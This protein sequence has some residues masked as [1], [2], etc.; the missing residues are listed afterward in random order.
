MFVLFL[1]I[2][3]CQF[4]ASYHTIMKGFVPG[5]L[6]VRYFFE[7]C[8]CFECIFKFTDVLL[9]IWYFLVF[10]DWPKTTA[11]ISSSHYSNVQLFD[12]SNKNNLLAPNVINIIAHKND[13]IFIFFAQNYLQCDTDDIS[14]C[15]SY[16]LLLLLR[17]VFKNDD[18]WKYA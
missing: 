3:A 13:F 11:E 14:I 16:F 2:D 18:I 4:P 1:W 15:I 12:S 10:G 6:K 17:N 8:L 5:F 9:M 7:S